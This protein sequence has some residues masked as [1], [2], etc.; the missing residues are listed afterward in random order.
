VYHVICTS[1][2]N[3]VARFIDRAQAKFW[4]DQNNN[5]P[6]KVLRINGWPMVETVKD[7]PLFKVVKAPKVKD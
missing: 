4:A 2:G 5:V 7:A 3:I 1:T 6:D